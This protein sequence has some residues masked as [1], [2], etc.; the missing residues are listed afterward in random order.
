MFLH[1]V[2]TNQYSDTFKV[3]I[4]T[5]KPKPQ[6]PALTTIP[7]CFILFAS[8]VIVLYFSQ[9]KLVIV[10]YGQSHTDDLTGERNL[11][12]YT[13]IDAVARRQTK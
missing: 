1:F 2:I 13:H 11:L 7:F 12:G 4:S 9:L 8:D 6:F 5:R 3:D 10:Y